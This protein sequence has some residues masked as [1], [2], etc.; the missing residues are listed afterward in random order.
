M[1]LGKTV[2]VPLSPEK[3]L[4]SPA[5]SAL[6]E[7]FK[8]EWTYKELLELLKHGYLTVIWP[9]ER[10]SL[11][12]TWNNDLEEY[13]SFYMGYPNSKFRVLDPKPAYIVK[14]GEK[15]YWVTSEGNLWKTW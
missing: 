6:V 8:S 9:A 2:E 5:E 3:I 7:K 12:L 4:S 15:T 10:P 14:V 13:R 1:E 11:L